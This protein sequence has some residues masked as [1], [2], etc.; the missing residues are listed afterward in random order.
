MLLYPCIIQTDTKDIRGWVFVHMELSQTEFLS[1]WHRG[2]P[3]CFIITVF[4]II[5][6]QGPLSVCLPPCYPLPHI[7]IMLC[8]PPPPVASL[9]LS[10][11]LS[12]RRICCLVPPLCCSTDAGWRHSGLIL[13]LLMLMLKEAIGTC[14]FC[15]YP[16]SLGLAKRY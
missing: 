7:L 13:L 6:K 9:L 10:S 8:S 2:K 15:C 4:T 12:V 3:G 16:V 14:Y 1:S 11:S 5:P